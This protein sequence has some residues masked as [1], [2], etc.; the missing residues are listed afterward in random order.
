MYLQCNLEEMLFAE[1][2]RR[3]IKK[4]EEVEKQKTREAREKAEER[5]AILG[6]QRE[7]KLEKAKKDK[8]MVD[9]EKQMLKEEWERDREAER[10]REQE[11]ALRTKDVAKELMETNENQRK[12][13][14]ALAQR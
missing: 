12:M 4:R 14:E 6:L 3:E 7:M 13:K 9:V 10:Q 8:E 2:N 5:N 11:A 1:L